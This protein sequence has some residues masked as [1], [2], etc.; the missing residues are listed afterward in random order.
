ME[1]FNDFGIN[2]SFYTKT[3]ND[4]EDDFR[5]IMNSDL[6][7]GSRSTFAWWATLIGKTSSIFPNDF[8]IGELRT[9]YHPYEIKH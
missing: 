9:L 8:N 6:V 3:D 7:V 1:H 4:W 5:L 2:L